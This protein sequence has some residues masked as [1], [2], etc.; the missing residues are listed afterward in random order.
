MK[1]SSFSVAKLLIGLACLLLI[2]LVTAQTLPPFPGFG[3]TK[4]PMA[5]GTGEEKIDPDDVAAKRAWL[6][7]EYPQLSLVPEPPA[8][9]SFHSLQ[10]VQPPL[11]FL[12]IPGLPIYSWAEGYYFYD[13]LEVNYSPM[14]SSANRQRTGGFMKMSVP[15]FPGGGGGGTNETA[16][17]YSAPPAYSYTNSTDLWIEI[18]PNLATNGTATNFTLKVHNTLTDIYYDVM[19]STNLSVTNGWFVLG[20]VLAPMA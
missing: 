18:V 12:P 6:F 15:E 3:S 13:D 8:R 7:L 16:G 4:Q 17:G 11:P 2:T 5:Q 9:G 20:G 1:K 14:R 10:K 19:A